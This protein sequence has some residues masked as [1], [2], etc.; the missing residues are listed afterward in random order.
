LTLDTTAV[1]DELLKNY[2]EIMNVSVATPMFGH[3][4]QIYIEPYK[5]SFILTTTSSNAFLLDTNGRALASTSQI[6]DIS[7]LGLPTLQDKTGTEVK[8]GSRAIP[9]T[10]VSFVQ[11]VVAALHAKGI[12][13]S[14]LTLPAGAYELDVSIAGKPYYAK[15]NLM[16]DALQ[17]SGTFLAVQGRLRTAKVIPAQ[18]IDVRV[19]ERA[20]YK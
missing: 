2:P 15:F 20:Y 8:L 18:Y 10:T 9:G 17:Q 4:P 7:K 5:P 6:P 16:N 1:R 3:Q 19:P 12:E 13:V 11:T 14:N